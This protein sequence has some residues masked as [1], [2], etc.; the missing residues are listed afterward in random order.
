MDNFAA[1][2]A[3]RLSRQI[4]PSRRRPA[5]ILSMGTGMSDRPQNQSPHFRHIFRDGF[6]R[7]GFDAW[8]ST[9]NSQ[10]KWEEMWSQLEDTFKPDYIRFDVPLRSMPSTIDNVEAIED[11]ENLV[12]LQP[13]AARLAREA[14]SSLLISRFYF[15]LGGWPENTTKSFWCR[16]TIR[17][18][19]RARELISALQR[20][21]PRGLECTTNAG[22]VGR[23][24]GLEEVCP[25]CERYCRPMS[26][27]ARHTDE[28]VSI[29]IR[30]ETKQRWRISG[31]PSSIA[32][33]AE[34]QDFMSPF[35]RR[36]H[37][38]PGAA[39]CSNC[40]SLGHILHGTRR[41]RSSTS[42]KGERAKRVRVA[43][44]PGT[45][46]ELAR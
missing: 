28:E 24:A 27:F 15:V 22:P 39:P 7:R 1:G 13:G 26:F 14:A 32:S 31:F 8:M 18:K 43:G 33:L 12:V 42:S 34:A 10:A 29:Y 25:T 35:G 11:Y 38:Q 9:M 3:R 46:P 6:L 40:D 37:G 20:L 23:F 16:G 19:G 44:S 21:H 17:C 2:I 45:S 30:S 4:W 36:D 41:K 5:R